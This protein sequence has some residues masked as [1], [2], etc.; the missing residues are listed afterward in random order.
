[1][2]DELW[3]PLFRR[4]DLYAFRTHVQQSMNSVMENWGCSRPGLS[5]YW[6][7]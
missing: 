6:W 7:E 5:A 2:V 4:G 3:D 1:M